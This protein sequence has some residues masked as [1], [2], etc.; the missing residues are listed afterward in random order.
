[1]GLRLVVVVMLVGPLMG[2]SQGT[3]KR[4]YQP[5][6]QIAY[7][8]VG[9][10]E[11]P[12]QTRHYEADVAGVVGKDDV[13][14]LQWR[15]LAVNGAAVP[16]SEGSQAFHE[17]LSLAPGYK[18][19]VPGLSAVQPMLIGPIT[20]LLTFYADVQLAMRQPGLMKAGDHVVVAHGVPNSWADGAYTLL[21]QD[22]IDFDLTLF[23]LDARS[24][25]ATLVVKHV[26]PK[27]PHIRLPAPW[28]AVPVGAGKNNWVQVQKTGPEQFI[29][30]VGRESF[31]AVI[32]VSLVSGSILSATL[33]NP[34][35]VSERVCKDAALEDCG[36]ATQYRIRRVISLEAVK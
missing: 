22:S 4:V 7:R 16:L 18:L 31:E 30:G 28:M 26:P 9:T 24:G 33:D 23:S 29:A 27:S 3:L 1:M 2:W 10:N 6:E 14:A 15:G 13:E 35:L 19:A 5:G 34:V 21:G 36:D 25:V 12:Q 32:R 8:M 20:D 17:R 11:M